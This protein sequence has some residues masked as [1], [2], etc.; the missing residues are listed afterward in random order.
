M[1]L[2]E[3]LDKNQL[4]TIAELAR[5]MYPGVKSPRTRLTNKLNR[6]AGQR[7]TEK[8]IELAKEVLTNHINSIKSDL[9][10]LRTN[11]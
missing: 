7:I 2:R 10:E 9:S 3:L 1:T 4:L 5:L 6:Y 11:D 8:D